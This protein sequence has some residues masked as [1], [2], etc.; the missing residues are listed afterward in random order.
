M[1]D[2]IKASLGFMATRERITFFVLVFFKSLSGLLD[3]VGI[4]LI[5]VLAGLA[6]TSLSPDTPLVVFGYS[7]PQV[8]QE[9]LVF[10][11]LV[12]LG[13]FAIKAA[14][15]VT[16]SKAITGFLARIESAQAVRIA[17]Y[18]F[19]GS[20]DTVQERTKGE[21][22]WGVMGSVSMAFSGLLVSLS[23]FITE[24]I[25]LILIMTTFILVD[26]FATLFVFLYF[27]LIIVVI[28]LVISR[29]LSRSGMDASRGNME[30][31]VVIDDLLG[32]YREVAIFRK[33]D[34]FI[35]KFGEARSRLARGGAS[36]IFLSGMPRYVVETAL[37]LGVVIFVGFQF[38]TGQLASGL[39]VVGVFLTGGV[40][41]MASLLPLQG[42]VSNVKNQAEQSKVAHDFLT[43]ASTSASASTAT[44]SRR[45]VSP[46][47]VAADSSLG[48]SSE[49]GALGVELGDVT[50]KYPTGATPALAGVTL[51]ITPGQHVAFIGPSGA[52]KTTL[53]DLILGLIEPTQGSVL[54][55]GRAP[56]ATLDNFPG[57]ISYV[58]QNPGIVSGSIAE[59]VALGIERSE[60]DEAA[61]L[62]ALTAANLHEF[63]A[64]LPEGMNSSVGNQT[65]ALSG[66]QIQRL[67]LA[68][69]FYEKPRLIVLDEATSALDAS[70]EALITQSLK[71]LGKDVTVIIIAHRLSTV[72]HSDV[73]F[74]LEDGKVTASGKFAH[75]RKTVPMV[76]EYVRLMSFDEEV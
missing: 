54:I 15:A 27:G 12:V 16:L 55:G 74:L 52:G 2:A 7:L 63:V 10:L 45:G 40:R 49:A 18:L 4:A 53:V 71:G 41:I 43:R 73:V 38:L 5:G 25:L 44:P 47:V 1:L 13:V 6:A 57:A 67:G 23:T 8:T 68:R 42:A 69:A 11:V 76:A 36:M 34:F 37:M 31:M 75:L 20:L 66:G 64:G 30:S 59:N 19:T 60:I 72:Q 33:Q 50:F 17:R 65:D 26:P 24:G 46:A 14:V 62:A 32:A 21:V 22:L 39:V 35:E 48:E 61:V 29:S 56:A 9:T 3:V 51:S 28:Q 70:S 58:P